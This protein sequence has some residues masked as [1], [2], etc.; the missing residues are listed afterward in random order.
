MVSFHLESLMYVKAAL[1]TLEDKSLIA[2]SYFENPETQEGACC[3]VGCV[4]RYAGDKIP[5]GCNDTPI[6]NRMFN[7]PNTRIKVEK[8]LLEALQARNDGAYFPPEV[9]VGT[10][11]LL[12]YAKVVEWVNSEIANEQAYRDCT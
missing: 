8:S 12:R 10:R 7:I 1:E 4:L 6:T 3:A 2:G 11:K 9:E 5:L